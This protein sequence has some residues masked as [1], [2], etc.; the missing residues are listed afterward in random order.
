MA[1][2]AFEP[3]T[4]AGRNNVNAEMAAVFCIKSRRFMV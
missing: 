1:E 2:F 4:V 3:K